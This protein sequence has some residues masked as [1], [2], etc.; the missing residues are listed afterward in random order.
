LFN[1]YKKFRKNESLAFFVPFASQQRGQRV[2]LM[3]MRENMGCS[4]IR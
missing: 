4:E 3:P 1:D 2:A